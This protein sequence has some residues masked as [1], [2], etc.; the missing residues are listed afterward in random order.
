MTRHYFNLKTLILGYARISGQRIGRSFENAST[1][2]EVWPM[3][4]WP[5]T[6]RCCA[7]MTLTTR[8]INTLV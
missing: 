7:T 3:S 4:T 8:L 1:R 6:L 2:S 5:N